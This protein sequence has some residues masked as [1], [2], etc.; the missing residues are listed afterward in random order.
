MKKTINHLRLRHHPPQI[1]KFD[2]RLSTGD[3]KQFATK[4]VQVE[5]GL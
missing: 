2:R 4:E 3:L 5:D 1:E